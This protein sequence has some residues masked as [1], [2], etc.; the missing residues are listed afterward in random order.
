MLTSKVVSSL[1]KAGSTYSKRL[2]AA[3]VDS[4]G[5]DSCFKVSEFI[6]ALN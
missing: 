3:L 6:A 1:I 2:T 4:S 5:L